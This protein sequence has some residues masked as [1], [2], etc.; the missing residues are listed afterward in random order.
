MKQ[1]YLLQKMFQQKMM[2]WLVCI[3]AG[4]FFSYELI[5]MHMLN[6]ISPFIIKEFNLSATSFSYLSATYLLADVCFL[7]PAGMLLDRY[8]TR[9][10]ILIAMG[11]CIAG[12]F[13]FALAQDIYQACICHFLSGIGNAFCFLSCMM[14]VARWFDV[15]K[16]GFCRR[17]C[18][19][20]WPSWRSHCPNSLLYACKCLFM[21]RNN[22]ARWPSWLSYLWY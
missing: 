1:K 6:S 16:T 10:I 13:G 7:I 2:A 9:H 22:P 17:Y 5:Q 18:C 15:K 14:L 11:F 19:N 21:E 3:S 20:N 4:L 8:S 12:T